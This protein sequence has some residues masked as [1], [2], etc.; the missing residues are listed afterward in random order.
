MSAD[1]DPAALLREELAAEARTVTASPA[2]TER[3]LATTQ[4][5]PADGEFGPGPSWRGWLLPAVAAA[6]VAV[7]LAAVLVG[8]SLVR[9]D[10][11][12][13]ASRTTPAPSLSGTPAPSGSTSRPAP[14]ASSSPSSGPTTGSAST[15]GPSG[16]SVL[17]PAGGPVPVGFRA[18]DLTWI[19]NSDGWALGTAPCGRPPCTSITRTTD[20]GK[21]WVGIPA[22][23]A[24]LS[25][26]DGCAGTCVTGLR[27][28]DALVGYAFGP[29]ALYLTTDGGRTW[30]EQPGGSAYSLE[31]VDGQALRVS[32]QGPSCAPGCTFSVQRAPVGS[33][34]WQDAGLPAGGQNAGAQ[35]S[36]SGRT[37][38][39]ATFGHTAG[40]AENAT[41]VLFTSTDAGASWR[42]IGEPCPR[43]GTG[44]SSRETDTVAVTVALDGS[45]TVLCTPRDG[46]GEQLVVTLTGSDTSRHVHVA[47]TPAGAPAGNVLGAA[48]A[49][50]LLVSLDRLYRSTD[51][52]RHWQPTGGDGPTAAVFI[53]FESAS[54]GRVLGVT[55]SGE[56]TSATVWTTTD[57]GRTW[58]ATGF[59]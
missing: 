54:V 7:L 20:G 32:G 51:D 8:T 21:T 16:S 37:V 44:P 26:T 50:T 55:G 13:P 53:G 17:G 49:S 31:I 42:K 39:L 29:N 46:N 40:G 48:S 1:R 6:V 4:Y 11:Q 56:S 59:R 41:S 9:S 15:T 12:P 36:A 3:I 33:T 58:T 43:I 22:P 18:V 10:R 52:G 30:A 25:Q 38:V 27:F 28:A 19:S 35:L 45:T 57:A 23:R 14:S 24:T 5:P 2:F 34:D 47:S